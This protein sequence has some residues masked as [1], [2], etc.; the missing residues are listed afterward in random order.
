MYYYIE[1]TEINEYI[2]EYLLSK[3]YKVYI[4]NDKIVERIYYYDIENVYKIITKS[5]IEFPYIRKY[6]YWFDDESSFNAFVENVKRTTINKYKNYYLDLYNNFARQVRFF[7]I[8]LEQRIN[9]I[10]N[11]NEEKSL[12]FTY[13]NLEKHMNLFKHKYEI[14]CNYNNQT[15]INYDNY[16]IQNK[17]INL[18][19]LYDYITD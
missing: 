12:T 15:F 14:L 5:V 7:R 8:N 16:K 18:Q 6:Y 9:K 2:N 10:T 19:T 1:D 4:I 17:I 3:K 11:I 13:Y